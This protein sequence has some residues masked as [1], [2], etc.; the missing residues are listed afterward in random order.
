[1]KNFRFN[2]ASDMQ[3]YVHNLKADNDSDT[4]GNVA[5]TTFSSQERSN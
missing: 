3:A 4:P 5:R 2:P 1:M